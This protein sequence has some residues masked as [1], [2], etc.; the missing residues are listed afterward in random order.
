MCSRTRAGES[1]LGTDEDRPPA[2]P[3]RACIDTIVTST[4]AAAGHEESAHALRHTVATRLVRGRPQLV[5]SDSVCPRVEAV[6][7]TNWRA[8]RA[9]HGIPLAAT[10][11][12]IPAP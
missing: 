9:R 12:P 5:A 7:C 10:D 11:L 3:S 1:R 2:E 4:M 8:A 6:I